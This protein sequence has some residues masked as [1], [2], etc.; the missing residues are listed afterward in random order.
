MYTYRYTFAAAAAAECNNNIPIA[1]LSPR[2]NIIITISYCI[3]TRRY[4]LSSV[5]LGVGGS[6]IVTSPLRR[7]QPPLLFVFFL[8]IVWHLLNLNPCEKEKKPSRVLY[9]CKI[10][11]DD[12][13]ILL[14]T[15]RMLTRYV[16]Q[17]YRNTY[18]ND[19][20]AVWLKY[21]Y[22]IILYQWSTTTI[23]DPKQIRWTNNIT[24]I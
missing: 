20:H 8:L 22:I 5:Q 23:W 4:V 9:A 1:G 6:G 21:I 15:Y 16:W 18:V 11:D 17:Q 24:C 10:I 19:L 3:I 14:W 12:K 7:T 13:I 2:Y